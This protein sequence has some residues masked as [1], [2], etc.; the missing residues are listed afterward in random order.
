MELTSGVHAYVQPDG[1]WCLNNAGF[2]SDGLA[3]L[4][5]DTAATEARARQLRAAVLASGA[6]LP[7][8][9]V[10]TH[11]HG[12]H[13]YGNGVF[14]SGASIVGHTECR[15]EMLATGRHLDLLWPDVEYGDVEITP[16]NITYRE[17][18]TAHVGGSEVQLIHPGPAH[19]TGDTIVWLPQQR[20]VFTGDLIFH[21]GTPFV[22][23][24][25]L[26]GSLRALE[27]LRSLGARTVVPG[28]G[29]VT[30][31][32]VYDTV[33]RYLRYVAAL[34]ETSRAAGLTPLEAARG[35]DPGEFAGLRESVRLVANLHRAY[36]ELEG[37]PLGAPLD[38]FAAFGDMA[39][40]NGGVM[41]PCHA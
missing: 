37:R 33:E 35:A 16:P 2:V 12:D 36:A 15:A 32:S 4:L 9:V 39:V 29:P 25:S 8:T 13:T 31:P 19:T 28:H 18:L 20:I 27:T 23:M 1:G 24:G 26:T 38:P 10:N 41:V 5:I 21:G 22:P 7:T 6:P 11:Y 34:A 3:T 40:L 17:R 30:D 14:A